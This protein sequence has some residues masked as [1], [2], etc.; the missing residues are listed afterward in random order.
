MSKT[1]KTVTVY[2]LT[3]DGCGVTHSA[4]A[5]MDDH[6]DPHWPV[7]VSAGFAGWEWYTGM[8]SKTQHFCPACV[9]AGKFAVFLETA[10]AENAAHAAL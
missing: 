4:R 10:R 2:E 5:K 8:T 3:C 7:V 6:G 1:T 9:K